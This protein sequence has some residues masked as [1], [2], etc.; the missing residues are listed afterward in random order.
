MGAVMQH[1]QPRV[2]IGPAVA[3]VGLEDELQVG[4]TGIT[5]R[6]GEAD[7]GGGLDLRLARELGDP[8][9]GDLLRMMDG[10][11]GDLHQALGQPVAPFED[12]RPQAHEN[13]AARTRCRRRTE[14]ASAAARAASGY[15]HAHPRSPA[16]PKFAFVCAAK[17]HRSWPSSI[18]I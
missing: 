7:H 18:P 16:V 15:L 2:V 1:L 4:K 11:V 8:A 13:H 17:R 14:P 12:Q 10:E 3:G 5:E 6:L 9:E